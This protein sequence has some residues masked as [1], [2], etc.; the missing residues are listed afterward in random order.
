MTYHKVTL[1][2]GGDIIRAPHG[3]TLSDLLTDRNV[4]MPCG[5]RGFCGNCR[6]RLTSGSI[7]L[8]P[9]HEAL[10]TRK[11]L[12]HDWY[13]ACMTTVECDLTVQLPPDAMLI[14][15]DRADTHNAARDGEKGLGIAVDLG[16][17]TIVAQLVDMMT[18]RVIES[19]DG[20]NPQTGY[21]AD[22]ISRITFAMKSAAG[23]ETLRRITLDC[24]GSHIERLL[25]PDQVRE[26]RT[27]TVAGN[28]AMHHFFAGLDT[29]PLSRAPFCSPTGGAY[30]FV[31]SQ[32]GWHMLPDTCRVHLLPTISHFIGSDI[33]CGIQACG[34]ADIP[35]WQMLIDLGTN[36]EIAL[37]CRDRIYCTSTAAGPAFEGL[38]MECGVRATP[39]AIYA[40]EATDERPRLLTVG[41]ESPSGFCGS[42]IVEAIAYML[43]EGVIDFTGA[44]AD[45]GSDSFVFAP[46]VY[47]SVQDVR[48]FQLAKGAL[49]A[50]V[51]MLM[52]EAGINAG[53]IERVILTGGMGYHINLEK[54]QTVG[55]FRDF[56]TRQFV[57]IPNSSL[58][59][60]R[61]NL[62]P[63]CRESQKSV[64]DKITFCALETNC[65]FQKIFCQEMFFPTD[66]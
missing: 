17:T 31:P 56:E 18:G 35:E 25:K 52:K 37:G 55:L 44:F 3:S 19:S 43:E 45:G 33:L 2:P 51:E 36:G 6:V 12:G 47:I 62:Y 11:Q 24:I 61:M 29:T 54:M 22:I 50:G 1:L 27:V 20:V 46:G 39:G 23:A 40:V 59:G 16:S 53:D 13:L 34:M 28:T 65:E 26:V 60:A 10:R 14:T 4:A 57:R 41:W 48:E 21:G 49:S 42:G 32:L 9:A 15:S 66:F 5:A 7:A 58:S 38:N 8:T 63:R 30:A 64:L